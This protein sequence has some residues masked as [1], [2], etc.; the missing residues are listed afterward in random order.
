MPVQFSGKTDDQS[1]LRY[2]QAAVVAELR[3][4]R[5]ASA[6]AEDD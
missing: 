2:S 4:V 1:V 6:G 5:A 3:F